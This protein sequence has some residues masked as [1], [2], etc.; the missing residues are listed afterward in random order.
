M[1]R[2]HLVVAGL[3]AF[4]LACGGSQTVDNP[5]ESTDSA[6][7]DAPEAAITIVAENT[8][9]WTGVAATTDGRIYVN[10]PRW[11][12]DVPVSVGYLDGSGDVVPF[13]D[14]T[15]NAWDGGTDF[16]TQFVAVQS[17]VAGPEATVWVLDTGNPGFAGVIEGAARLFRFGSD[18]TLLAEYDM[19][20]VTMPDT[21][22]NDIRFNEART[23]GYITDS[24]HGG[25]IVLDLASGNAHRVLDGHP[26][27]MAEDTIL[28]IDGTDWL[29]GGEA[30]QVHADGIAIHDEHLYY[31]ALSARTLYRVPLS[32]LY[33]DVPTEEQQAAVE[34][35]TEVGPSDGLIASP[36]GTIY[37]S[38]LELNAVRAYRPN[39]DI[40]VIA[41]DAI[42]A[43]PDSFSFTQDGD[44]LVTT[45]RIHQ[46]AD[47]QGPYRVLRIE[48]D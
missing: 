6:T 27:T 28:T 34:V 8:R 41:Q 26:S 29:R 9:Q 39:G 36:D 48:L 15:W 11:S 20:A 4:V 17:V 46:G 16:V 35:L 38:S 30:P 7:P 19:G 42:I 45:A 2:L 3:F 32:A 47:P 40:E 1:P 44:L 31:Q 23:I 5:T 43:W 21:Y 22:L 25:L 12:D 37:L 13:P 24:G 33:A 10:F 14:P 18:G